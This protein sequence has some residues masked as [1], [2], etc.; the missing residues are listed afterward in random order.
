[1]TIN[2]GIHNFMNPMTPDHIGWIGNILFIIGALLLANKCKNGFWFNALGN[3]LYI[4]QG[5]MTEMYSLFILSIFLIF[6]NLYGI[7]NWIR[8]DTD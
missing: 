7:L 5:F 6:I 1:M 2:I 3:I 8:E 4:I